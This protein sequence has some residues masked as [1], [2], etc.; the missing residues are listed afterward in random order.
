[1]ETND[2]LKWFNW[3]LPLYTAAATLAICLLDALA[4]TDGIIY[5]LLLV[6]ISLL[7]SSLV[8]F[9]IMKRARLCL[10]IV[11][12]LAVFWLTSFAMHR[13][14]QFATTPDGLFG[15]TVTRRKV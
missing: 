13:K 15:H 5:L 10:A 12:M 3:R 8:I 6:A 9:A 1:M 2:G 7:L 11:S 14:M 4:E